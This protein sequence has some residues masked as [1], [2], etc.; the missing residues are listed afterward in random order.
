VSTTSSA[1]AQPRPAGWFANQSLGTKFGFLVGTVA[2]SCT[3]IV[4]SIVMGNAA[5]T[6]IGHRSQQLNMAEAMV[7]QLDT[8]ASELKVD[9]YK[10]LVRSDPEA[11]LEELAGDTATADELIS[12]LETAELTGDTAEAVDAVIETFGP[13]TEAIG[14]FIDSAIASV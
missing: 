11:Q 7:M 12:V 2:V 3:G 13:Y 1:S 4:G 9:G 6:E 14:V 5:V 10:A 8:R